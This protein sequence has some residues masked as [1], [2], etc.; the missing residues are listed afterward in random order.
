MRPT[1]THT[2]TLSQAGGTS[3][4]DSTS[5]PRTAPRWRVLI[6][7]DQPEHLEMIARAIQR[8]PAGDMIELLRAED[9]PA[10][11][12]AARTGVDLAFLDIR[13]PGF[14]GLD[15]ADKMRQEPVLAQVPVVIV[16]SSS[17]PRDV[18]HADALGVAAYVEKGRFG[19]F[20]DAIQGVLDAVLNG[21][22]L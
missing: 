1:H 20:R 2:R 12:E 8:S 19:P 6:A 5:A 18:A 13:M 11:L 10:A 16:S 21:K 4:S 15:V 17:D 14:S 7:D 3:E 9:G 22:P